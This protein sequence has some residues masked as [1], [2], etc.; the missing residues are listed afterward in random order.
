MSPGIRLTADS[1]SFT[2]A[3]R[4]PGHD[5]ARL[6]GKGAG[7]RRKDAVFG[8][9]AASPIG[10]VWP[11]AF[12]VGLVRGDSDLRMGCAF[13]RGLHAGPSHGPNIPFLGLRLKI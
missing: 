3:K 13:S 5:G 2:Y 11:T 10:R 9:L 8:P 6:R 12:E 4:P 1:S 7:L